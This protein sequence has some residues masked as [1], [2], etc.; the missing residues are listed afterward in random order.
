MIDEFMIK[1][2][3]VDLSFIECVIDILDYYKINKLSIMLCN[4]YKLIQRNGA[5][6]E[7]VSKR[8]SNL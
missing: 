7:R 1:F 6:F 8:Y 5:N 3:E 4:R 2:D